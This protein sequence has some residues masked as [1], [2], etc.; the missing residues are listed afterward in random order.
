MKLSEQIALYKEQGFTSE[1]AEVITLMRLAAG[2]LFSAFPESFLLFG[3]A[4]LLLFHQSLRHSGDLDLLSRT[5][6]MPKPSQI[7]AA[8]VEGLAS[9]AE[10]LSLA[11]LQIV[12]ISNTD[13]DTKL[14][15]K[16]R[17]GRPLFRID[18]NRY[19][20][21]LETEVVEHQIAI[22]DDKIAKVKSAS[23]NFLLLQKA[24]CFLLRKIVKARDGFDIRLL[25]D[26]GAS[27]ERNLKDHLSDTLMGNEIQSED[28]V[29]R[30]EEVDEK[31]CRSELQA[32]LPAEVFDSLAAQGFKP[33]RDSLYELYAEWL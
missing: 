20:S 26:S 12:N 10:A 8:L 6:E 31:R 19:G 22:D 4:T 7:E 18:L 2:V 21:V 23:R 29:K 16:S 17:D 27:L 13:I 24:E 30:I 5:D 32:V 1:H 9:A 3:G 25:S 11:P 33:M 15:V 28:I 14:W